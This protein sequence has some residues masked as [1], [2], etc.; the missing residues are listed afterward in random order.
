MKISVYGH[1][2]STK[3]LAQFILAQNLYISDNGAVR[4][5]VRLTWPSKFWVGILF[6]W[7]ILLSMKLQQ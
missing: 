6:Q 1:V 4:N 2:A 5:S 3:G 7:E